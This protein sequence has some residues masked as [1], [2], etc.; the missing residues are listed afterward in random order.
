MGR[1]LGVWRSQALSRPAPRACLAQVPTAS[2][3]TSKCSF[4]RWCRAP[5]S[6]LCAFHPLVSGEDHSSDGEGGQRRRQEAGCVMEARRRPQPSD[7]KE[8]GAGGS[9]GLV[10]VGG[11]GGSRGVTHWQERS[12]GRWHLWQSLE[13]APAEGPGWGWGGWPG[14][15]RLGLALAWEGGQR[16][17]S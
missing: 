3:M 5:A 2:G 11:A 15:C 4:R 13:T 17:F 10:W 12:W 1:S 8:A 7:T 9:R 16:W 14:N 6:S